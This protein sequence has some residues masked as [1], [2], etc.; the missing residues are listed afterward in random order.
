MEKYYPRLRELR[1]SNNMTQEQIAE[2]LDKD[3]RQ[4]RRYELG[5]VAIPVYY[6]ARLARLYNTSADYILELT[7]DPRPSAKPI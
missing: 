4:Y 6:L 5:E 3:P 1:E 2:Y 7:D